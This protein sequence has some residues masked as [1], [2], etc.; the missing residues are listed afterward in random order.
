FFFSGRLTQEVL[1][2]IHKEN[3]YTQ[4]NMEHL[5]DLRE[6][7][8]KEFL[9]HMKETDTEVPYRHGPYFYYSRSVKGKPYKI[10]CRV[11]ELGG[12]EQ[13]GSP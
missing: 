10:R 11:K 1:G 12:Q 9:G 8:Y 6:D 13:V 2:Y 4:K 5:K 7:L 3:D